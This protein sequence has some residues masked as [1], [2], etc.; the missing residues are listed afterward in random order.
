[1][2]RYEDKNQRDI[3]YAVGDFVHLPSKNLRLKFD[4]SKKLMHLYFGPYEVI[5]KV[6]PAAYELKIPADIMATFGFKRLAD[7]EQRV[8]SLVIGRYTI[9]ASQSEPLDV[10]QGTAQFSPEHTA[11][12]AATVAIILAIARLERLATETAQRVLASAGIRAP[13]AP[14]VT[15]AAPAEGQTPTP[16]HTPKPTRFLLAQPK[17][18][19]GNQGD[20]VKAWLREWPRHTCKAH[21]ETCGKEELRHAK[22][23]V[24]LT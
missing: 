7:L 8:E 18:F 14:T 24:N 10:A 22:V 11:Q 9:L 19:K 1:M 4:G 3:S 16:I 2:T 5:K 20:D 21:P 17:K 13:G 6:G 23:P 15:V 12:D